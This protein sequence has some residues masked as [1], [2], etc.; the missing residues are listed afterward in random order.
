MRV[1]APLCLFGVLAFVSWSSADLL[2]PRMPEKNKIRISPLGTRV[3]A[4]VF[5]ANED[6]L[7][8]AQGEGGTVLALYVFDAAGNCLAR[9]DYSGPS[10]SD[11]LIVR[12]VPA[13][14][15]RVSVEVRNLGGKENSFEFGMR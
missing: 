5:K 2:T 4:D 8:I 7:V 15:T 12:W 13:E 14:A 6:A 10:T 1:W 11:D 9:D 3:F